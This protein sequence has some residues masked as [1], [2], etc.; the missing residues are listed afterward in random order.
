MN[1]KKLLSMALAVSM[2]SG[3]TVPAFAAEETEDGK[4]VILHTNDVHCAIDQEIDEE[5]GAVTAMGYAS[6]A[7]YQAE[8]EAQYGAE[9]VTLID[10]GDA[11]QGGPIGTLSD[12]AYIVDIMNQVGY[13]LA[14][15]GNHEFDYGMD[16]FLALAQ[17]RAEYTYLC[18]NLTDMEG[19]PVLEPYALVEYG[20]VT[21]GY[22]GIDTPE[23]FTKSTPTYFQDDE[24]N[25]IYSFCQGNEG[26]DLY[27]AVQDAVDGAIA[28]GADYVVAVGHLG[29]E[30]S[31]AEWT[32]KS[33]I[34]N[35]TGIDVFI[36]GHSHETY[37][38]T[39]ENADGETVHL[40]QTG[41]KLANI[42]KVVIDTA[43]GE[44]T[45]ELVSGYAEQDPDAAAYIASVNE[46]F[47]GI[48]Q[49]VVAQSDVALTTL[50]PVTG[51]RAVRNAETNLG[52]LCADAY[53]ILLG[54]DIA[55]VNG[56]GVRADIAAGEITYEDII[57]VHPFGNEACLVET[58]GQAILD[59]LEMGA[60]LYPEENGG[61]LQVSGLSYTID[62]SVP[63]SVVLSD[64]GEF[65]EVA[66]EYRV[67]DVTVNGE[68]L[69][70]DGTYTLASHNYMLKSGGDGFVMFKD[71]ELLQDSVMI[72]NAVLINYIVDELGG[73]V[74]EAYADPY[75]QG[76][77]TVVNNFTTP[78]QPVEEE[79]AEEEPAE[80]ADVDQGA[81]YAEAVNYVID[82]G[83]MG[84]TVADAKVFAPDGTVTRAT[85]FQTLYNMEGKPA[86]SDTAAE[87]SALVTGEDGILTW[88][89]FRD[90]EGAWYADAANWSASVG[91]ASVPQDGLFNGDRNITRAEIATIFARYAEYKGMATASGDLSG[92]AD[93][94]DVADWAQ[95]GMAV[96]VGSGI[97][98]GK[99]GDLLDPNGNAVRTEL[100]TI[101]LNYSKLTPAE[102][103]TAYTEETV[104][105]DVPETDG[106]P[107]HAVPAI[108]TIP[109]G[110][111]P[112]PVVVMLHG[113]GTDKHEAG[114]GYD[115]A[116]A[117]M[118][119]AGIATIRIDFMGNGDST[120]SY[121]DYC[122]TS[123][124][125]D[126]KAAADYVA[127][128]DAIDADKI[129]V[130]GWSQGGTNAL[131][132]AA[133]YPE[134]FKAV[135]TWAGSVT[136]RSGEEFEA[137]YETAKRDGYYV[138]EYDWRE[139]QHIGLRW[140]EE[141][142]SFRKLDEVAKIE[143]PILAIQGM[144]DTS[145]LP[146]N[147]EMIVE[148]AEN[149][150]TRAYYIEDCDHT[151]NVFT[152][153]YTAINE[154]IQAGIGFFQETLNG[155]LTAT[156]TAVSK[157]G[158]VTTGLSMD[159]VAGAGYEV[160]DI[161]TLTVGETGMDVPYGTSYSDVDN[162][163]V[164]VLADTD[165]NTLAAAINMGN[166]AETY[167]A[168][169]GTVLTLAMK[170][171]G[172]YL[173]EYEIRN[174]DSLRTNDRADYDSDEVFANFRPIVM[175]DIA[176]GVLYRSSSPVNPELGRNT[177]ADQLA[178]AAGIQTV[179]NLADSQE[180]MEAYEGYADTYYAT[181]NVIGLDM[182]VDFSAD[183]FN[184]KLK[185]GLEFML[186]NE[187]PYL[188]HCN[189]GKDRAGFVSALL[190]ALMGG[191]LDEIV[192]DYM[193]S[194]ENYYHVEKDSEQYDKIAESNIMASLRSIAGLEE[195]ADLSGVDLQAAA[196]TYL[197][198]TV[199]LS[200]EQVDALQAVLSG[201]AA[202]TET[203]QAA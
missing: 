24:G 65:V 64:E 62:A 18:S 80:W 174:I 1:K 184:A 118:A 51:E 170:E 92:Y 173:E 192:E 79:P 148:N 84:S 130:M 58:S 161:V 194:Y 138:A 36:D 158:N 93:V 83:I 46:E 37:E 125:L 180:V 54:A 14:V 175:G 21:V 20:D 57:N 63:S 164:I 145:V 39:V 201:T 78:T 32:S 74:G 61:F 53:R 40:A 197:T 135:V 27:D 33:V 2:L 186:A 85:V 15:P 47:S 140:Y 17:E 42:G 67:K 120:A 131:F 178:E 29:N 4:I 137:Q 156:V 30:G 121:T 166:F 107:A 153:D 165:T 16:N 187:G 146:E 149:E 151:F 52:D 191:T 10:G 196:G 73:V 43:T 112:F 162:G 116:A 68:P 124:N 199:G 88:T 69:D 86:V 48:L 35:T 44:I 185:T 193:T 154:A 60:H 159:A 157:Y 189:E 195:G 34:A 181:L 115:M 23:S 94:A 179:I 167:S 75:G 19:E 168:P 127:G 147:A 103:D 200:A 82:N 50:D 31:T 98:S 136:D 38:E 141:N 108:V 152:G 203:E 90:V 122:F 123:A 128:L 76:R 87:G 144:N 97:L 77:I 109:E 172:G 190:E 101:L 132:A 41:T 198:E 100:A 183:D 22:V 119:E 105:I 155:G 72:D 71:D 3:L 81:W 142:M 188:I 95:E 150:A 25:Y 6:V 177:Y 110:E 113:T 99:P 89:A 106:I 70:L 139:P 91:L 163:S 45:S 9:N 182:G 11:I 8:M 104:S 129:A 7:A 96:A 55:F 114:N 143:A 176:E 126:A 28:G 5:T 59:A 66:G 171:K 26:Q 202:G 49:E 134:T 117:A 169:E 12:G 160:G 56:G 133:A 102:E 13:D 111:G